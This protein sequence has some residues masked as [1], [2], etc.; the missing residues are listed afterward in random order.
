M[1]AGLCKAEHLRAG[2]GLSATSR[3][4]IPRS[5]YIPHARCWIWA[6]RLL[7]VSMGQEEGALLTAKNEPESL[8]VT[9][10]PKIYDEGAVGTGD[11]MVGAIATRYARGHE[12]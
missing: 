7:C 9:T 3:P 10:T 12:V 4:P 2:W 6:Q 1:R 11:A 8:Y 5:L